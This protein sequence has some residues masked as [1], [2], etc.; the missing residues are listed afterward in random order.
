MTLRLR[1]RRRA[2][3]AREIARPQEIVEPDLGHAAEAAFLFDFES[4]EEVLLDDVAWFGRERDVGLE[5]ACLGAPKMIF[6]VETPEHERD[7]AHPG[8]FEHK[9]DARMALA[10]PREDDCAHQFG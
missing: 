5:H 8:F 3:E 7:P 2:I 1:M 4:E 9:T 6:A 10:D